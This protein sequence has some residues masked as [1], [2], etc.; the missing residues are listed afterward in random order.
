MI[1]LFTELNISQLSFLPSSAL[2]YGVLRSQ[3]EMGVWVTGEIVLNICR[4]LIKIMIIYSFERLSDR[5]SEVE[6]EN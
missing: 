1:N 6:M 5:E 2:L 4:T 3:L